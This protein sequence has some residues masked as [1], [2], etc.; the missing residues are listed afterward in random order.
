M[1][2][3]VI[4]RWFI[5]VTFQILTEVTYK[6]NSLWVNTRAKNIS[7]AFRNLDTIRKSLV[8][9]DNKDTDSIPMQEI[10]VSKSIISV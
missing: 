1:P 3:H 9:G 8:P 6:Y 4:S 5:S 7:C 10:V 2:F